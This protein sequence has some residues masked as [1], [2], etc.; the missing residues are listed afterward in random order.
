MS[1]NYITRL[2]QFLDEIGRNNDRQWFKDHREEYDYVRQ[3]WCDDIKRLRAM[4]AGWNRELLRQP[5]KDVFYRFYR[6]TRFSPDKSPYKTYFSAVFNPMGRKDSHASYYIQIGSDKKVQGLYGGLWCP[7]QPMLRKVR[8]AVV[9]NIE[10]FREIIDSKPLSTDY[11]GWV[12]DMLKTVPK[13][14]DRNHPDADLL[15]LKDL[16]KF[17]R[18]DRRFFEDGDWV[19]KTSELFRELRPFIDFLNYS[20]DE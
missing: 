11:P 8:Q 18:C 7:P 2:Y 3:C 17:H 9:D 5:E 20:I 16:G 14:W 15:R 10:E 1:G 4:M 13:G 19:E 12:G 6:D